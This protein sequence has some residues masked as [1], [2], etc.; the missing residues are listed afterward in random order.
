MNFPKFGL[1]HGSLQFVIK[2]LTNCGLSGNN[3]FSFFSSLHYTWQITV[4]NIRY[5]SLPT[6]GFEPQTSGGGSN[7]STNW[8]STTAPETTFLPQSNSPVNFGHPYMQDFCISTNYTHF[9]YW[10]YLQV[11]F[12][13]WCKVFFTTLKC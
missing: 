4:N 2:T 3:I 1:H 9:I 8:A 5:K 10:Q 7:C 6:T 11:W 13:Q 12:G